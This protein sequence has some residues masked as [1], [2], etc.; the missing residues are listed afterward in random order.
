MSSSEPSRTLGIQTTGTADNL[1]ALLWEG[2]LQ[3]LPVLWGSALKPSKRKVRYP[4]N[5]SAGGDVHVAFE[6]SPL[7]GHLPAPE[8]D[9]G[10]EHIASAFKELPVSSPGRGRF[11]PGLLGILQRAPPPALTAVLPFCHDGYTS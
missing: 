8:G 3:S 6:C 11:C 10:L 4:G 5:Q 7:A 2:L 9:R 1:L